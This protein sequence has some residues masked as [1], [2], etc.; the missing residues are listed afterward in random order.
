MD[1]M[2]IIDTTTVIMDVTNMANMTKSISQNAK[3]NGINSINNIKS[4][5]SIRKRKAVKKTHIQAHQVTPEVIARKN[6]SANLN[7]TNNKRNN[8][9]KL[10]KR[11]N[12]NENPYKT[13][14]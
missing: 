12:S 9:T 5:K 1:T 10:P 14:N 6:D 11:F 7:Q 8:T 4:V 2:A 3:K 13:S